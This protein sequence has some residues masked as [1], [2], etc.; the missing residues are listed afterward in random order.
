MMN[1]SRNTGLG[2]LL[3]QTPTDDSPS[4]NG[5]ATMM[6]YRLNFS[7]KCSRVPIIRHSVLSDVPCRNA[8]FYQQSTQH[9]AE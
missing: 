2:K 7:N 1:F 6:S 3:Y 5:D 8:T 9:V 4:L